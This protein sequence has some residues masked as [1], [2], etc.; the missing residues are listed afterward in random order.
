MIENA[1]TDPKS[2]LCCFRAICVALAGVLRAS[3]V[4]DTYWLSGFAC[5]VS[6]LGETGVLEAESGV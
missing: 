2:I 5:W 3:F 6:F 1:T 4:L